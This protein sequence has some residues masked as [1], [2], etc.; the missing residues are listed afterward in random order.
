MSYESLITDL[1]KTINRLQEE[2]EDALRFHQY[3]EAERCYYR[4]DACKFSIVMLSNLNFSTSMLTWVLLDACR[5]VA[6]DKPRYIAQ[7]MVYSEVLRAIEKPS[8]LTIF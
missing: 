6:E 3:R 2:R 5:H 8:K 1:E 7:V 4:I